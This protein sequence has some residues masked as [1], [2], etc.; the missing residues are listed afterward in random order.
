MMSTAFNITMDRGMEIYAEVITA[1][2][3]DGLCD[4]CGHHPAE[5]AAP[6]AVIA[7]PMADNEKHFALFIAGRMMDDREFWEDEE[8]QIL[9][10]KG[11]EDMK[12]EIIKN[13]KEEEETQANA[14]DTSDP[15]LN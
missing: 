7:L 4:R 8:M 3:F 9:K 11:R 2:A 13:I 5:E 6:A 15:I 10:A 12:A 1:I 14:N